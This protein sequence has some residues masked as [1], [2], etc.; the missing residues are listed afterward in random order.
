ME[1]LT[2]GLSAIRTNDHPIHILIVDDHEIIRRGLSV[3]LESHA[4][5]R[6]IGEASNGIQALEQ[7]AKLHPDVV[8]MDLKMPQ[9]DGVQATRLI[10][11]GYPCVRV[12]ILTCASDPEAVTMAIQA[13]AIS[14]LEKD[15]SHEH[16]ASAIRAAY[17]GN[18]TLSPAATQAI[19]SAAI[20]PPDP[21]FELTDRETEVLGLM[22][23]GHTNPEIALQ[24]SVSRSTVKYHISA[25]LAKLGVVNRS[26]AVAFALKNKLL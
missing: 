6:L 14:Y 13:G 19:I 5:F 22:V 20:H 17:Q 15:V 24:L 23:E 18:R 26:E 4:D 16:L 7:C 9:M 25:I 3:L 2:Q 10:R 12:I 21:V 1:F 8:L 11:A